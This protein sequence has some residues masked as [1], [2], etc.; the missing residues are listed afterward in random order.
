MIFQQLFPLCSCTAAD[1]TLQ[2]M[3]IAAT[4]VCVWQS[5]G[6]YC[7]SLQ[8]DT[9][10][11][12]GAPYIYHYGCYQ[13]RGSTGLLRRSCV[14]PLKDRGTSCVITDAFIPHRIKAKSSSKNAS[15]NRLCGNN[16]ARPGRYFSLFQNLQTGSPEKNCCSLFIVILNHRLCFVGG[17]SCSY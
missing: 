11:G 7:S 14:G 8:W 9:A 10:Q 13:H 12:W 5:K 3:L 17:H 2:I 15:R 4:T 1:R 16:R 6:I